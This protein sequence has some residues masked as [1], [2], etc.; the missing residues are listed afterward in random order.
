MAPF[1]WLSFKV[2][3]GLFGVKDEE[4]NIENIDD[5]IRSLC[6]LL[7]P[8]D[9]LLLDDDFVTF[10]GVLSWKIGCCTYL[11]IF[12]LYKNYYEVLAVVLW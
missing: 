3:L 2:T 4:S 10:K 6:S 8:I 7:S 12:K 11:K 1:H 9:I 5:S